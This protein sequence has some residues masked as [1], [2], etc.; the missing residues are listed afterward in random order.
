[1]L[2]RRPLLPNIFNENSLVAFLQQPQLIE[3][4]H[5]AAPL[6]R[7]P[8]PTQGSI[9]QDP[10]YSNQGQTIRLLVMFAKLITISRY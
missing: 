9:S 6:S 7:S 5:A 2:H 3:H 1:M 10:F 8:S 4:G